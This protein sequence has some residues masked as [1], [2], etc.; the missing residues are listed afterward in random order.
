MDGQKR[1]RCPMTEWK[2]QIALCK[3]LDMANILYF[4][5]LSE[6]KRDGKRGKIGQ[7]MGRKAGVPD[8]VI[9]EKGGVFVEMKTLTGKLS[10]DQKKW[11]FNL[12][13]KGFQVIT[14]YG[15]Q[16]A[17]KKLNALGFELGGVK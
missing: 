16:D 5:T 12:K 2:H 9:C 3:I 17:V 4:A 10:D 11:I 13:L 7:R 1:L 8:I 6:E 15:W 14:G